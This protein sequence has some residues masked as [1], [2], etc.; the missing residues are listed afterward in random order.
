[1]SSLVAC[2]MEAQGHLHSF[3]LLELLFLHS[4]SR[5]SKFTIAR[6]RPD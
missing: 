2:E 6:R 4:V 5:N 3:Q 1:M